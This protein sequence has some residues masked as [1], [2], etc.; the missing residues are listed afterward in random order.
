ML[1]LLTGAVA[2]QSTIEPVKEKRSYAANAGWMLWYPSGADGAVIGQYICAGSV[3]AAN[4]GW[5]S[6]GDGQPGPTGRYD[7]A[8]STWGVN[9]TAEPDGQSARLNGY[10]WGAN[11]GWISFEATGDPRVNLNTGK[12]TGAIW[13]A[14][15]GWIMLENLGGNYGPRTLCL[16][17]GTD[18]DGDGLPDAWEHDTAGNLAAQ[19]TSTDADADGA[20]AIAE[21]LFD[22]R[23]FDPL[24]VFQLNGTG[25]AGPFA[26]LEF[27]SSPLRR[28]SVQS[29]PDLDIW[30]EVLPLFNPAP[31]TSTTVSFMT[32]AGERRFYR[33]VATLPLPK[34]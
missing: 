26:T 17:A 18:T 24:S 23:P 22:T 1:M 28:Y 5:I 10:A 21:Y 8:G 31:G 7:N 30:S 6:L 19:S 16:Q 32:A 2:A 27:T 33:V 20:P 13:S 9:V 12:L 11:I 25:L 15:A 3:Y 14:N 34:P 4:F 29:S